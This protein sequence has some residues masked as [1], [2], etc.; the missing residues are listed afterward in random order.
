M[1]QWHALRLGSRMAGG[2]GMMVSKVTAERERAWDK[3]LLSV[4][5]ERAWG[6]KF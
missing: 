1:R 6:L 2:G 3:N 4:A 5:R